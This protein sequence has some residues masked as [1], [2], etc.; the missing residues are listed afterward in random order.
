MEILCLATVA[1]CASANTD[2]GSAPVSSAAPTLQLEKSIS[3]P[4]VKGGFDLMASDVAGQRLFVAASDNNTVEVLD[5]KAG[6]PL[7]SIAGFR[8]PKGIAYLPEVHKLYVSNKDDGVVDVLDSESF[9]RLGKIEF[10]SKAN[11]VR[12]DS[13]S[14]LVY[15]G[16]G[17]GAI[18]AIDTRDGSRGP[19]V[20]LGSYPK[21]FRLESHG[22]RIFVNVP[23]ANHIAVIDRKQ[24]KVIDI[25]PVREEK[26]NIPMAL[27]E[28]HHRLLIA[29]DPGRFVVVNTE[30]GQSVASLPIKPQ[31][32]GIQ[33]DA[34]RQAV[35]VSCG[36]GYLHVIRQWSAD[37]YEV[38]QTLPTVPGAGTSLFVPEEDRLF[39]AV[40][41]TKDAPAEIRIYRI[42]NA[43]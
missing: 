4:G 39:L 27:D 17:D 40:P 13:D 35:Y 2:A 37:S 3:L 6:R 5:L 8:Q 32:D 20:P 24:A 26:S 38:A 30:N 11:N 18:G 12:Y 33:Y 16:Y 31:A 22:P 43:E 10:K 34:A 1:G 41:Q 25:W 21:Q 23:E 7:R 36:A 9:K 42:G 15:V 19:D 14:K 29:C 28:G